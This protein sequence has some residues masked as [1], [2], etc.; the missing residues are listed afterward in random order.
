[1][2]RDFLKLMLEKTNFPEAARQDLSARLEELSQKGL[3]EDLDGAVVFYYENHFDCALTE[4][5]LQSLSEQ[6]G[7][8]HYTL[9]MLLLI[10]AAAPMEKV[11]A[12]KHIPR[13]LFW[14]TF[15]D[16]RYMALEC[17][18]NYGV[19]VTFVALW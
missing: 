15:A 17:Y 19:W 4:E 9:W 13:E 8:S 2:D 3:E 10:E 18:E 1:M 14:E 16:L 6:S 7:I 5:L 11:F 12:Q